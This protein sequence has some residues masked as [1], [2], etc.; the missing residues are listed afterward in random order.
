MRDS[1]VL[2]NKCQEEKEQDFDQNETNLGR[3][4]VSNIGIAD[5]WWENKEYRE[6][7]E[8]LGAAELEISNY[9]SYLG[10]NDDQ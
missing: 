9:L 7:L 5:S 2:Q 1:K 8:S 6:L 4:F 3:S 10:I